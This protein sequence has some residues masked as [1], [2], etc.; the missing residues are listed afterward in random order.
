MD[1]EADLKNESRKIRQK[2]LPMPPADTISSFDIVGRSPIAS[3]HGTGSG[4][5]VPAASQPPQAAGSLVAFPL[6]NAKAT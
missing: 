4:N 3:F 6:S 1:A 2:L 5:V